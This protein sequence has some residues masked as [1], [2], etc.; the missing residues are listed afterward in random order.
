ME[1]NDYYSK[2]NSLRDNYGNLIELNQWDKDHLS[3]SQSR[4]DQFHQLCKKIQDESQIVKSDSSKK[5]IFVSI[6]PTWYCTNNCYYCY[7]GSLRNFKQVAKLNQIEK[8]LNQLVEEGCEISQIS[9]YGGEISTLDKQYL[10]DLISLCKKYAPVNC[11]TNLQDLKLFSI[12]QVFDI[13]ISISINKERPNNYLIEKFVKH[14][15]NCDVSV[16]VLPSVLELFEYQVC[17]WLEELRVKSVRFY[18]Y[19]PSFENSCH[20]KLTNKVYEDF[21]CSIIRYWAD[22]R[23]FLSFDIANI[24]DQLDSTAD[25]N[26]FIDPWARFCSIDYDRGR[27]YFKVHKT[28]KDYEAFCNKEHVEYQMCLECK[29][30]KTDCQAKHIRPSWHHD[31]DICSGLPGLIDCIKEVREELAEDE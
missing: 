12:C 8:R 6:M 4:F 27:E 30:Y 5:K 20:F 2:V 1:I 11:Q 31:E 19:S 28:L 16:V 26:I 9:L 24:H 21:L 14:I 13:P 7:L 22:N 23:R 10:I 25:S 3:N 15:G 18:Q 17:E 29:H